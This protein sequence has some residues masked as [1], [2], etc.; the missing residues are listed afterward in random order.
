M[1]K[2]ELKVEH[3]TLTNRSGESKDIYQLVIDD[4]IVIALD[5]HDYLETKKHLEE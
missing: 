1:K 3:L 4:E 2:Y 5:K